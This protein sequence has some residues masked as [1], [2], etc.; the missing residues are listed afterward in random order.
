M[1]PTLS[2]L[3]PP[4]TPSLLNS[5]WW[6]PGMGEHAGLW[7]CTAC[8]DHCWL[9]L[10]HARHHN[11]SSMHQAIV[12]YH[13]Q[14]PPPESTAS[15]PS[16]VVG[17]LFELLNNVTHAVSMEI[18]NTISDQDDHMSINWDAISSQI[19]GDLGLIA[20]QAAVADLTTLLL[21]WLTVDPDTQRD[22]SDSEPEEHSGDGVTKDFDEPPH[23]MRFL[24]LA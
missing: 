2:M 3:A 22:L 17:P 1:P 12:Q 11:A 13:L 10:H 6:I 24:L 19:S 15:A 4:P 7:T 14:A 18:D 20:A 8:R 23:G 5:R 9:E 16:A 21:D